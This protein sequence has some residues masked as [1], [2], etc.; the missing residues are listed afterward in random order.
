MNEAQATMRMYQRNGDIEKAMKVY[1]KNK[2]L[3]MWKST[4]DKVNSQ[5]QSISRQIKFIEAQKNM[6]EG[7]KLDKVRQL[8]L[9]KNEIVDTLKKQVLA[10]EE[11]NDTRVKRQTWW[12]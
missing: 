3:L 6:T 10:L 11:N 8:N 7:E 9:L 1:N 12:H 2:N 5:L 4:Y